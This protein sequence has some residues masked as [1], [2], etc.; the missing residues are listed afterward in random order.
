MQLIFLSRDK[1]PICMQKR[2]EKNF[3]KRSPVKATL[4]AFLFMTGSTLKIGI[5]KSVA[6]LAL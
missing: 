4:I 5:S 6:S 3:W 1:K 2:K